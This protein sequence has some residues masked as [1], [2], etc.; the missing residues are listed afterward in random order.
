MILDWN[1]PQK[2]NS[3]KWWERIALLFCK[4]HYGYDWGSGDE[5]IL[6]IAKKFRGKIYIVGER[7]IDNLIKD[8]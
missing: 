4:S 7:Q 5:E 1:L 3:I 8:K 2:K 6:V